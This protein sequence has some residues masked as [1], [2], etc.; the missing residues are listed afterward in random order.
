MVKL[1]ERTANEIASNDNPFMAHMEENVRRERKDSFK[2]IETFKKRHVP[3]FATGGVSKEYEMTVVDNKDDKEKSVE[4]KKEMEGEENAEEEIPDSIKKLPE[5]QQQKAII[6]LSLKI[7]ATGT[8]MV[9][10]FSDPMVGVLSAFGKLIG[11]SPFYVSFIL[12][13]LASNGSEL[14]A[15]YS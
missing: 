6:C 11:V 14:M 1:V 3:V 2:N 15:A 13:P 5:D 10:L 9:I 12:A 7:M 4:D 8:F